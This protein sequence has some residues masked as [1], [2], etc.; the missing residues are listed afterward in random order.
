[1]EKNSK[2]W[3]INGCRSEVFLKGSSRYERHC[4][5]KR[6][7]HFIDISHCICSREGM[8][9]ENLVGRNFLPKQLTGAEAIYRELR[10]V[11]G[12]QRLIDSM[13]MAEYVKRLEK[14]AKSW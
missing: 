9:R 6:V 13:G 12:E 2:S 4:P 5:G 3:D 1:M 7:C 11:E 14:L 10:F 8:N